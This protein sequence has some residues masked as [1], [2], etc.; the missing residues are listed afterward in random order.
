MRLSK[1]IDRGQNDLPVPERDSKLLE[2]G[3]RDMGKRSKVD[4]VFEERLQVLAETEVAQPILN[5]LHRAFSC[6]TAIQT[7]ANLV[8]APPFRSG[9]R[10]EQPAKTPRWPER[11]AKEAR[12]INFGWTTRGFRRKI[13]VGKLSAAGEARNSRVAFLGGWNG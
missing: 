10:D 4:V 6:G 13:K 7:S 9:D 3:V 11:S 8:A 2:I 5:C 12:D 1:S